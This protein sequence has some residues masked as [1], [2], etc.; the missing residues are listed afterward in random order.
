MHTKRFFPA[1]DE[2]WARELL[3]MDRDRIRRVV[4]AIT[5]HCGL[6]KHLAKMGL[7][8]D[9]NCTCG[10]GEE[11]GLHIIFECPKFCLLRHRTLGSHVLLPLE[12]PKLGPAALDRFLVGTGRFV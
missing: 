9:P 11:T 2:K 4:G 6:S 3:D 8:S 10:F 5:G 1:P 12:V 7:A